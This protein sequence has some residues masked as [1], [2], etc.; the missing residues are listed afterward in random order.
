VAVACVLVLIFWVV[1]RCGHRRM[2]VYIA[3]CSLM[4]SLTVQ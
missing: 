1:E 2:L 3:I 4:G